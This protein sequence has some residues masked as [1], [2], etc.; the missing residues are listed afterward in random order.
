MY[1][2]EG[3]AR[4]NTQNY[5]KGTNHMGVSYGLMEWNIS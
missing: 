1:S 4:G 5:T 3:E 2:P